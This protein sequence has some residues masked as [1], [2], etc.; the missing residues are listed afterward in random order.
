LGGV[1]V[2]D[3]L[4]GMLF[5]DPEDA[6]RSSRAMSDLLKY[7][8]GMALVGSM[9][10]GPMANA[11]MMEKQAAG[12]EKTQLSGLDNRMR[13]GMEA[14]QWKDAL[15]QRGEQ[16]RYQMAA[17]NANAGLQRA[18][19]SGQYALQR[20]MEEIKGKIEAAKEKAATATP[21]KL[22]GPEEQKAMFLDQAHKQL[23]QA[24]DMGE[25]IFPNEGASGIPE[26]AGRLARSLGLPQMMSNKALAR[27]GIMSAIAEPIVRAESGAAVPENEVKRLSL[28][29]IPIPGESR[30]EQRRKLRSLV[31]AVGALTQGMPA[32][33]AA[34]FTG[35]Q[36]DFQNWADSLDPKTSS[37]SETA[38]A[39]SSTR[40]RIKLNADGS[41][42][43]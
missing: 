32:W 29:Y 34:E 23:A 40:K 10:G 30:V 2:A 6:K 42:T 19:L 39:P 38:T 26:N 36:K 5:G 35:L 27:Q 11:A 9:A 15:A 24:R 17:L 21:Q 4:Y 7:K 13:Y 20:T 41:V 12:E 3:D 16:N 43:E 28:R 14:Q 25:D 1:A 37:A 22:T 8:K 33:K 31:G 18:D